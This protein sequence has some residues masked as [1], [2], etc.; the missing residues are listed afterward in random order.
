MVEGLIRNIDME[1]SLAKYASRLEP[2]GD[3]HVD[4][5]GSWLAPEFVHLDTVLVLFRLGDYRAAPLFLIS[6]MLRAS[7]PVYS[8]HL[9]GAVMRLLVL[10]AESLVQ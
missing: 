6:H 4:T 2:L 1:G 8:A 10:I 3:G 7:G 5:S 9:G